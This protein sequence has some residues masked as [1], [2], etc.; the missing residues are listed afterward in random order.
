MGYW[1]TYSEVVSILGSILLLYIGFEWYRRKRLKWAFFSKPVRFVKLMGMLV[2][3]GGLMAWVLQPNK[4]LNY[5]ETV[6]SG[7]ITGPME[8]KSV[9]MIDEF[10]NDTIA[11]IPV[12]DGKFSQTISK[13]IPLNRYLL[14][15]DQSVKQ[16]VIMS[17]KDSVNIDVRVSK[18][19][20]DAKV[21]GTRLAENRYS[22]NQSINWS[23]VSY[24]LEDNVFI[25][26]PVVFTNQLVSEWKDAVNESDKFRTADNYIPK[27]DYLRINKKLIT[28]K[29]LNYCNEFLKKR[30]ALYPGQKTEETA[31]IA[32]MKKTVPLDDES[33]LTNDVYFEY[34]KTNLIAGNKADIDENT[35]SIQ[36]ITKMPAGSFKDKMLYWQLNKSL[37]EASS[38]AERETL[39]AAYGNGFTDKK[40]AG[41]IGSYNTIL[42]NLGSGSAAPLFDATTLSNKPFSLSTLKGSFVVIDVWATWCGPCKVQSPYFEKFAVKY[43]QYPVQFVALST[44]RRLDQWLVEAKTKSP[45]V[46]QLHAANID[47][48][49]KDYNVEGIPRFILIG[50]DGRFINSEMPF[51]EDKNFEKL[52][53]RELGLAEQK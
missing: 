3:L 18:N 29:Y 34:L 31:E 48:F 2:V 14:V 15:F 46:L 19:Q 49:L 52:L 41:Y 43:K 8:Y 9:Y 4:M 22:S 40:L 7:S 11:V 23:T 53:R 16:N 26:E 33:L 45:T 6:L 10:I 51:P 39:L 1:L 12:K 44:D 32:E 20:T 28:I 27:D 50:K 47:K 24:Y 36:A 37:K 21:T 5:S 25:D 38:S 35:K 13:N 30:A 42:N 17:S